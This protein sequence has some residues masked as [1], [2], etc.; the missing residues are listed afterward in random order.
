MKKMR[1]I[2]G[3]VVLFALMIV[4]L[5][6]NKSKMQAKS[7]NDEVKFLPVTLVQ[8]Q[9]QVL[10]EDFSLTGT[11]TA[12]NDVAVL[13][14]TEGRVTKVMVNV[15][16]KV[17]AGAVLVQVDDE[18]KQASY[19]AAE[20]NYQKLKKDLERYEKLYKE[21]SV[22][23]EQ[24]ESARLGFKSAEAQYII[25]RR[26]YNDTKIKSPISGIVSA[27][28]VDIG[29]MVQKNNIIAN[30]VDISTLKVK[31]NVAEED[32]FKLKV[33]DTAEV[34]TDIY[35]GVTFTGKI[36]TIS[37]KGDEAHTYPVEVQLANSAA[38][39]LR[40]GMFGRVSFVSIRS[41]ETLSIPRETLVGSTKDA[42]VFVVEQ[43]I[44]HLRNVVVGAEVGTNLQVLSGLQNDEEVVLSG[45]NNL[46]DKDAVTVVK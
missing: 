29:A 22:S 10:S 46:K 1:I 30:V 13:S 37:A 4:V 18:L 24:L 11:I 6:N 44:A 14:E 7:K 25:A 26:Q 39:P 34:T 3:V 42:Q 27:R 20:V 16:D 2:V 17:Q 40:A 5:L 23:N 28:P 38:H 9:K 12:F 19:V 8:V 45:Q 15:G 41:G 36:A 31:L 33:G 21:S 32:A 35:P 43:G